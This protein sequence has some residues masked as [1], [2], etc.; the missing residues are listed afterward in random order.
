M[1]E[2]LNPLL[3]R[4]SI[5]AAVEE[6]TKGTEQSV[7]SAMAGT[8]AYD[9]I[10]NLREV[11]DFGRREPHLSHLD[12]VQ[13]V[14]GRQKADFSFKT[15]V[16]PGDQTLPLLTGCGW[17]LG[18]GTY[19][20]TSSQSSMKTWSFRVYEDGRVK[21]MFGASMDFILTL[22]VGKPAMMEFV[23]QGVWNTL[24]SD[25]SLP[26]NPTLTN[27]PYV[28]QSMTLTLASATVPRTST[29]TIRGGVKIIGLDSHT[30][31]YGYA[32][33]TP[34]GRR[35]Q[36]V[37]DTEAR[38][39]ADL[40]LHGLITTPTEV[41][42]SAVLTRVVGATTYSLSIAAPKAQRIQVDDGDRGGVRL[43]SITLD[44]NASATAGNDSLTFTEISA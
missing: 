24:A 34:V 12:S 11:Y 44:C 23:A 1:A 25:A 20:P 8:N 37:L 22:E 27:P 14:A 10:M 30:S 31:T 32:Y 19:S 38:L 3:R 33:F 41:A 15:M 5:V 17:A 36:I 21:K 39:K 42:F 16:A 13:A 28:C 40:D 7:T 18:G 35:P 29:V 2:P 43:D 26:T 9:A 6:T 4:K